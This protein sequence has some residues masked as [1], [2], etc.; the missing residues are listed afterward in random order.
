MYT[1]ISSE[2]GRSREVE[3]IY[4]NTEDYYSCIFTIGLLTGKKFRS[5]ECKAMKES[6]LSL[7]GF[8]WGGSMLALNVMIILYADLSGISCYV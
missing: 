7:F 3:I 4:C 5:L 1:T 6:K 8:V 2:R